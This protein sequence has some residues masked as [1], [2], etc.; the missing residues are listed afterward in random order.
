[1]SVPAVPAVE[2][3]NGAA[4]LDEIRGFLARYVAFPS[5]HALV[6]VVLWVAHTHLVDRFESTPRLALLSP[7]KQ[8]G[9]T[10]TLELVELLAASAEFLMGASASFIFRLIGGERVTVL[11]DE[12][13]AIWSRKGADE[14]AEAMRGIVNAGHRK[15]AT[16]GRVAMVGQ[17]AK[18][19]RFPVYA[20][21][22]LAGIGDLPDTILDRSVIVRMRR[23]A[24]DEPV[25]PYRERLSRPEGK[26]LHDRLVDWCATVADKVGC[27]RPCP[28][29]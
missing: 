11:L 23:R 20:S 10:R 13:D 27:P 12:C 14:S 18:L 22:A 3:V 5:T 29:V 16:V 9:K 2:P 15:G 19:E 24:P 7:E 28:P 8:S 21:V 1:M 17:T 26:A 4:L 25:E 6:A